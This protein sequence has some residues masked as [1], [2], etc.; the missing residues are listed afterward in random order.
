MKIR[1]IEFREIIKKQK[2]WKE[3]TGKQKREKGKN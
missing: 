2:K 3:V 1:S